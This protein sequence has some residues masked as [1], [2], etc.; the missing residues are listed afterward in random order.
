MNKK[1]TGERRCPRHL[2]LLLSGS[3]IFGCLPESEDLHLVSVRTRQEGQSDCN[4]TNVIQ[5]INDLTSSQPLYFREE[6]RK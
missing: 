5:L 1:S 6:R 4:M 3:S 2:V